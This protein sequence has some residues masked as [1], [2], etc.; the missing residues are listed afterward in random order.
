MW[1]D[2]LNNR[3]HF[4]I[5]WRAVFSDVGYTVQIVSVFSL[6]KNEA[7]RTTFCST[8]MMFDARPSTNFDNS[9]FKSVDTRKM[10]LEILQRC[11]FRLA[12][13]RVAKKKIFSGYICASICRFA[14]ANDLAPFGP[15]ICFVDGQ[16]VSGSFPVFGV[17]NRDGE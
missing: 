7:G 4:F 12:V 11:L 3:P 16:T 2:A 1:F 15:G 8:H 17:R 14:K 5:D 10:A 6:V 13:S 9:A